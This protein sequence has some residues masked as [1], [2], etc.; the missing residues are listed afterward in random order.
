SYPDDFEHYQ[1]WRAMTSDA[2]LF[3]RFASL[4]LRAEDG[5]RGYQAFVGAER[6]AAL[7]AYQAPAR[8][9]LGS[10]ASALPAIESAAPPRNAQPARTIVGAARTIVERVHAQH[11]R[12]LLAG[13]GQS[14]LAARLAKLWLA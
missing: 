11:Y 5:D 10:A 7:R 12:S 4:V 1:L 9:A 3:E 14:F 13:I 2:K 6:L 8:P